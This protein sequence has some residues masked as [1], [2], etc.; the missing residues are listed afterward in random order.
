M[1]RIRVRSIVAMATKFGL[2]A[3]IQSPT[4]LFL[5]FFFV[6]F[7]SVV[8][9]LFLFV[10]MGLAAWIKPIDWLT[11]KKVVIVTKTETVTTTK[12]F[13]PY[14]Q[15]ADNYHTSSQLLVNKAQFPHVNDPSTCVCI[16][17]AQAGG[18]KTFKQRAI[19][20]L[21]QSRVSWV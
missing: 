21:P 2:G 5:S 20:N 3:E 7:L 9:H 11:D 18:N 19:T 16:C 13:S 6:F 1:N 17:I 10:C 12:S 4:G 15:Y 8:C 14:S